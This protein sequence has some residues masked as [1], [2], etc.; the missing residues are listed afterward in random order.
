MLSILSALFVGWLLHFVHLNDLFHNLLGFNRTE[1][2]MV[3]FGLGC[4]SVIKNMFVGG[5]K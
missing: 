5:R 3:F 4:V 1:Y 2:Y